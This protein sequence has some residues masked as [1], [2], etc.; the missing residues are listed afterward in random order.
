MIFLHG[1]I[2]AAIQ[3]QD[4]A[5][6]MNM[7][8]ALIPD[9]GGHGSKPLIGSD[10]F[11]IR[12][13]ADEVLELMNEKGIEQTDFFGYSM[14]GYIALYLAR[15]H[16]ERVGKVITLAT[17]FQWTEEIAQREMAMLNPEKIQSKLPDFAATLKMRHT[18]P[19]NWE[20]NM[21]RTAS[22]MADLGE[23][24][25]LAFEDYAHITS[26]CLIMLGDRD[27]MVTLEETI[28]VFKSL[29]NAQM[30]ILSATP[31]P[32]EQVDKTMLSVICKRF[33][34]S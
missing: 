32:I 27:K 11:S 5:A 2:G 24:N 20:Q 17:K 23:H 34:R 33:L 26:P 4:L 18:G 25:E 22:M 31:H 8:G 16:P 7:P 21:Q 10:H 1:A 28:N 9:L 14:G 29:S 3:L 30:E 19:N 13:F 15:H 6:E 12:F